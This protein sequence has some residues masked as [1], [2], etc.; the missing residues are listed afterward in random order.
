MSR[1]LLATAI[2][3]ATIVVFLVMTALYRRV[4][5]TFLIPS[6]T[7]TAVIVAVLIKTGTSYETY[8]IG[9]QWLQYFLGPAVVAL[10][11]PLYKQFDLLLREWKAIVGG[12]V[13]GVATGMISGILFALWFGFPRELIV[14]LLPKSITTPVA[15]AVSNGLGGNAS[16]T[17]VF[18]TIAGFTGVVLGPLALKMFGIHSD[19][20]RGI[21]LGS[22]SHAL[23][24]SKA[25]EFSPEAVSASTVALTLS[26][27]I[28]AILA[29]M[30]V[31]MLL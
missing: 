12:A 25:A 18:V 31:W 21:G 16:L 17:S 8:M 26:A 6:L 13:T 22:A 30:M 14:S 15:M 9:G 27:I 20:G 3:S 4:K 11:Y 19:I 24:T 23:G 1:I 7:S 29:P 2:M 5:W 10:A 28:G